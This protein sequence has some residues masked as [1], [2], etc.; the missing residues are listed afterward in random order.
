MK[1]QLFFL[2]KITL[3]KQFGVIFDIIKKPINI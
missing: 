2:I 1:E 3:L